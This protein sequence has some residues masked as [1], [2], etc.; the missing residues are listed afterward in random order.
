[1]GR[2]GNPD[3]IVGAAIYLASDA[4]SYTTGAEIII[5]GG[6]LQVGSLEAFVPP[7]K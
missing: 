7:G 5:D 6:T 4:S 3:E 2:I 1:M